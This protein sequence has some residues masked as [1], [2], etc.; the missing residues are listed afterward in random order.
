[1]VTIDLRM[2]AAEEVAEILGVSVRTL[3]D[4]RYEGRGP[5]YYRYGGKGPGSCQVRYALPDVKAWLEQWRVAAPEKAAPEI[6]PI[7][8]YRKSKKLKVES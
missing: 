8:R 6:P 4:W 5:A 7:R 2:L 3:T 1:M